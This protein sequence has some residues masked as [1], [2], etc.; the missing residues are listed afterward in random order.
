MIMEDVMYGVMLNAK[1]DIEVNEPPVIALKNPNASEV[2]FAKKSA[3]KVVWTPGIGSCDPK[4]ITT[5]IK[6]VKI[7][8]FLIS[9]TFHALRSVLSIL[10][11]LAGST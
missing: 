7:S 6:A 8:F 10:D 11:H 1:I 4:R 9:F 2:C 3:K 5:N